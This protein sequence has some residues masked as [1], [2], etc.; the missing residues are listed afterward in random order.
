M[1]YLQEARQ[2]QAQDFKPQ[3]QF[4][5]SGQMNMEMQQG[6]M[7]TGVAN[8][9]PG[10]FQKGY[11]N[12]QLQRSMQASPIPIQQ[13]Q[14]Q[15][16]QQQQSQLLGNNLLGPQTQIHP[17]RR[18]PN[19]PINQPQP[20]ANTSG[21]PVLSAQDNHQMMILAQQLRQKCPPNE[22]QEISKKI[23]SVSDATKKEWE[24][25]G[26]DPMIMYFRDQARRKYHMQKERAQQQ[27][28]Q[29][30]MSGMPTAPQQPPSMQ[31]T[32]SS[33]GAQ[34]FGPVTAT[35]GF[36]NTFGGNIQQFGTQILG[37]Q[38]DG[39]RSQEEGQ[40]VVPASGTQQTPQ[41]QPQGMVQS[42]QQQQSLM[43]Q[44]NSARSMANHSQFMAQQEKLQQVQRLQARIQNAGGIQNHVGQQNNLQGQ[45]GGL[46][47]PVSQALPQQSPAMPNLNRPLG[48]STQPPQQQG[49][50]QARQQAFASQSHGKDAGSINPHNQQQQQLHTQGVSLDAGLVNT[51]QSQTH[52]FNMSQ[53]PLPM[54]RRLGG[55]PPEQQKMIMMKL[56]QKPMNLQNR[57]VKGRLQPNGIGVPAPDVRTLQPQPP[58]GHQ[59]LQRMPGQTPNMP[60]TEQFSIGVSQPQDMSTVLIPGQQN[61][62]GQA[63]GQNFLGPKQHPMLPSR[64]TQ[65]ADLPLSEEQIRYMDL[66]PFPQNILRHNVMV[67][68][69]G[70]Q[71]WGELKAWVAQNPNTMPRDILDKLKGLQALIYHGMVQK[72]AQNH[73]LQA[74][75][76]GLMN[77]GMQSSMPMPQ[78]GPAPQVTMLQSRTGQ[79]S[80]QNPAATAFAIQQNMSRQPSAQD[81]QNIRDMHPQYSSMTDDQLRQMIMKRRMNNNNMQRPTMNPQ[82]A[83]FA[84]FQQLQ[85]QGMMGASQNNQ[86]P[87]HQQATLGQQPIAQSA[88]ATTPAME[89]AAVKDGSHHQVPRPSARPGNQQ[90]QVSKGTKRSNEDE[91][92]EVSNPKLAQ[93]HQQQQQPRK[94]QPS[95]KQTAVQQ[96]ST[97]VRG[98]RDTPLATPQQQQQQQSSQYEQELRKQAAQTGSVNSGQ[99]LLGSRGNLG[100]GTPQPT[101]EQQIMMRKKYQQMVNEVRQT[102]SSRKEVPMDKK[103]RDQMATL[104]KSQM[105][106]ILRAESMELLLYSL[107]K[108][109]EKVKDL[110][111]AVSF[112]VSIFS[113]VTDMPSV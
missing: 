91:V 60:N 19:Q 106:P 47:N 34:Q 44:S 84:Q 72:S 45:A 82:Q 107:L 105:V 65:G 104:L 43:S 59:F 33:S 36:D 7:Q 95:S 93:R 79:P 69:Q 97:S 20:M 22:L 23:S 87:P 29:A 101:D 1:Q 109:E 62:Q 74:M 112:R 50:S 12:A 4:T 80:V 28:I 113:R 32:P 25:Q 85:R 16:F 76:Q 27:H 55:L 96:K 66:Q 92:V 3:M 14:M 111:R 81:L 68:P 61:A 35:Q 57:D 52:Q 6:A 54:Q 100:S 11:A 18:P 48:P 86:G 64:V 2:K 46:N 71:L 94:P 9:R 108:D 49:L 75:Q 58:Q 90:P 40:V 77:Q 31:Q 21:N 10:Q 67:P 24:R 53:L 41:Q 89:P 13:Q 63:L 42:G 103:T 37:L 56:M 15:N 5:N 83:Q 26:I 98:S 110:I 70:V 51:D 38:Q 102:L 39:I 99:Q 17:P 73:Q 88:Q 78:S 30:A 8:G